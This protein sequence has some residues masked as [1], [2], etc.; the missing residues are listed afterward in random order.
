MVSSSKVL[1]AAASI[2]LVSGASNSSNLTVALVRSAPPKW[3]MPLMKMDWTGTVLNI[4]ETVDYGIEL[5][6]KAADD[7]ADM[8][9][10]PE[11][12]FPGFPKGNALNNWT[13]DYLPM[14]IE[15]TITIGD[16]NW[17][18]LIGAVTKAQVYA[19]LAYAERLADHIYMTQ[20][21]I[22]PNG[23]ILL[24]RHK[25]RP[26][27]SER[28]FFTDGKADEIRAVTTPHGRVGML[29][30]G[31]HLYHATRFLM[32]SQ[33]EHLHLGP[34]PYLADAGDPDSLW[35]ENVVQ[36]SANGAAYAMMSGAYNFMTAIGAARAFDP[37]GNTIASID[38]AADMAEL[39][40][41]YASVDTSS[42]NLSKSYDVDGQNSWAIVEEMYDSYPAYIPR[43]EGDYVEYR[44]KSVEWL[45]SGALTT[46]LGETFPS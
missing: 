17:Q 11:L 28:W 4:S 33:F 31:E 1:V 39:P 23:S 37:L 13:V 2:G 14:Y 19:G 10:F 15:N 3:P 6:Q 8:I 35:W 9:T 30:C 46:E 34:F 22:A 12:W 44:E 40:M 20:T 41:L 5:I 29:E 25:L 42:F 32:A 36:E 27:G 16:S 21:L 7:G 43:V 24:H 26:S 38:A 45:M 18:R